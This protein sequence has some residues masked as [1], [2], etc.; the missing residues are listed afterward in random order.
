VPLHFPWVGRRGYFDWKVWLGEG[1]NDPAAA[2]AV[3]KTTE[4]IRWTM[5]K[6]ERKASAKRSKPTVSDPGGLV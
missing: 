4:G 1:G 5:T 3:C 2:K 6:E